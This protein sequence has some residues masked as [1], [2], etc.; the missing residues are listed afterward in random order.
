MGETVSSHTAPL[1]R[2]PMTADRARFA[3]GEAQSCAAPRTR[4]QQSL[5]KRLVT[6]AIP[7]APLAS[8]PHPLAQLH[9]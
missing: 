8:A 2:M 5:P 3:P 4:R 9:H 6:F 1:P 7:R